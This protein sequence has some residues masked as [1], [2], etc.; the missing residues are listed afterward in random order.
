ML[1]KREFDKN[2]FMWR[3]SATVAITSGIFSVIVFT[4]LV[5]NQL[6]MAKQDPVNYQILLDLRT[7]YA[8]VPERDEVLAQKIRDL[9]ML[10]RKAIFSSQSHLNIGAWLLLIGV[11]VFLVSFKGMV[12]WKPGLP[13]LSETPQAEIEWE[14]INKARPYLV[15]TGVAVLVVGLGATY[16]SQQKLQAIAEGELL[17]VEPA[18]AVGEEEVLADAAPMASAPEF[19]DWAEMQKHWPSFR[20]PGAQGIAHYTTAPLDWD[21]ESGEGVLWKVEVPLAGTNSP[22]VWDKRVFLSGATQSQR[23]VYCFDTESGEL[24][25]THT[26]EPFPG[27]PAEQ[28]EI[29][30]ETSYAAP[31]LVAHGN[32]VFAL[33]PNGDIV[34]CDFEGNQVW[35]QNLGLPDN[36]Y[37]HSS[38]LIAYDEYV[39]VQYDDNEAPRVIA[40][41]AVDG[42]EAWVTERSVVSWASP[43]LAETSLGMQLILASSEDAAGYDPITGKELWLQE[44][45]G[46][47]VGPSPAFQ[48]DV[49]FVANEYAVASAIKL[50]GD[51]DAVTPEVLWEYDYLL[52]E[53]A[54]P[55]GDGKHFYMATSVGELVCLDA[56]SGEEVWAEELSYGFYSS[57]ILVGDLI[58][59]LDMEGTMYIARASAD[60]ELV[61]ERALGEEGG[62]ATPA[63][64]DGRIYVRTAE[65]LL[66]IGQAHAAN[67]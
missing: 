3:M 39:Y 55:V 33:F 15:W 4:L 19:P 49:V 56:E 28:P 31:T 16:M 24:L 61:G 47:E 42:S 67:S 18:A 9:D 45:L 41:N 38:S 5:L 27:T 66:C 25:W 58:Y 34:C 65:H 20:G 64:L 29:D 14:A 43:I 30:D 59:V 53:V 6:Q 57:P 11:G 13:E 50:T 52:P 22:V 12:R 17:A 2:E 37:G 7:E 44:C 62:F 51:A 26:L 48:D 40:L 23:D 32:R 63:F 54:S 10:T 35:G 8:A 60:F 36:H 46:G 1:E 21:A